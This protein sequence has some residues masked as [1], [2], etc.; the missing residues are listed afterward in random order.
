[1]R[2]PRWVIAALL[3]ASIVAVGVGVVLWWITWP[4]RTVRRF[5]DEWADGPNGL[6]NRKL[7]TRKLDTFETW[8]LADKLRDI[9]DAISGSEVSIE[10]LPRT[11][12][13][14]IVARQL[15]KLSPDDVARRLAEDRAFY[16]DEFV[17]AER[18]SPFIEWR[19]IAKG[20]LPATNTG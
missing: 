8:C 18:G 14:L 12:I 13:D 7:I 3:I 2:P 17:A 16:K 6:L 10:P 19:P 1:M 20:F 9:A 15:F 11:M 5:F 4:E